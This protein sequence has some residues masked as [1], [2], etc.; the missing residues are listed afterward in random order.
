MTDRE[1]NVLLAI[2]S[3]KETRAVRFDDL[4]HR[5]DEAAMARRVIARL[6]DG[7]AT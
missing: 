4:P 1:Y 5:L 3:L 7:E 2:Q 6:M